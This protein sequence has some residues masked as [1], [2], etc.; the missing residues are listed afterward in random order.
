MNDLVRECFAHV[1]AMEP[2]HL[3]AMIATFESIPQAA[4]EAAVQKR[5]EAGT[6]QAFDNLQRNEKAE[7]PPRADVRDGVAH[8]KIAGPILKTVPSFFEMFGIEATSTETVREMLTAAVED[9]RV[10]SIVLDIDSPGGTIDGVAELSGDVRAARDLKPVHAH[11]SDLMASAAYWIGCQAGSVS[12]GPTAA[13]G[14]IGVYSVMEDTSAIAEKRGI[15]VHVIASHPLKGAGVEGSKIT[16]AQL[17]DA[18]RVI[19][20]YAGLFAQAVADGR[21]ISLDDAKAVATGQVW[22]GAECCALLL[23]DGVQGADDA[24]ANSVKGAPQPRRAIAREVVT[25]PQSATQES[26]MTQEEAA[27]ITAENAKLKAKL[28]AAEANANAVAL[29]EKKAVLAK[30]A[31]RFEPAAAASFDKLAEVMSLDE[32]AAHMAALPKVTRA[33]APVVPSAGPVPSKPEATEVQA[34]SAEILGSTPDRLAFFRTVDCRYADGSALM[35][36]GRKLSKSAFEKLASA[37]AALVLALAVFAAPAQADAALSAPRATTCKMT[38][39]IK[40]YLMKASTTIYAGG[41]VMINASGTAEPAAAS[42]SNH[43]VVGVA[44]KTK[45][46]AASGTYLITT[47]EGWCKFAGTTLEQEDVGNLVYAESDETVDETAGA[48]EPVAGLLIEYES[49]SEG[50]VHVSS[51]YAV[52]ESVADPLTL[53]GDLTASGGAGAITFTDSASSI[54]VPDNDATALVIGSTDRLDLVTID[55]ADATET[56][57]IKGTTTTDALHVDIGDVQMDEDLDVTGAVTITGAL[58]GAGTTAWGSVVT[59]ANTACNTTCTAPCLLGFATG[60]D[61]VACDDATA[62]VC[63]CFGAN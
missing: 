60:G 56:V 51:I 40:A 23:V 19:N 14:S 11:A 2:A 30:Y 35:K 58:S 12:C 18:Q 29:R 33:D 22:I 47:Q 36:D 54:V 6:A 25:A 31:D 4:L 27:A 16:D 57:V 28:E 7:K 46:S 8:I 20:S 49:A 26:Q 48:N 32:L 52:R 17:D 43:G 24:H 15:K 5:L 63:V 13:V 61:V 53:T 9:P 55:S 1:W 44:T 3:R 50:W 62:D 41:L 42:A 59:G 39:P 34:K 45:T 37:A 21:G 10:K 38:G